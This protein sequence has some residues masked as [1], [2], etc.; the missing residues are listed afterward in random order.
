MDA[1]DL[2]LTN[3]SHPDWWTGWIGAL[4]GGAIGAI[5]GSFIPLIWSSH[6]RRIERKGEIAGMKVELRLARLAMDA[7]LDDEVKAPLY[8]LPMSMFERG[9][10]KLVG[11]G[12]PTLNEM[13][14]LFEYAN[15]IEEL[16]RGLDRAREA[17]S[18]IA[19]DFAIA[20]E[21]ERNSLKA[22]NILNE[23]LKRHKGVS[24]YDGA[25]TSLFRIDEPALLRFWR[26]ICHRWQFGAFDPAWITGADD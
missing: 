24:L 8:R 12:R 22:D 13:A 15:R 14:L 4:V 19:N 16:N 17:S 3:A 21:F 11:E 18:I 9:L 10:P 20:R 25:W 7:L 6:I 5:L 2:A 26:W 1:N 23:R